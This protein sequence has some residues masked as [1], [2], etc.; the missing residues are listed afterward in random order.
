MARVEIATQGW[1]W[2]A[3]SSGN[4]LGGQTVTIKHTDGSN[5]THWS[6]ITGGSSSTGTITTASNGT[7]GRYIEEGSYDVT[8][9]SD[10][11]R[12]EAVSGSSVWNV[13]AFGAVGDGSTNDTT[14][15]NAAIDAASAAGGGAV[16]MPA[17]TYR[18]NVTL[19]AKVKLIGEG[20]ARTKLT[21][22]TNGDV[23]KG[24]NFATLTG[25]AKATGDYALGAYECEIRDMTID[26]NKASNSGGYGIRIWGRAPLFTGVVRVQNCKTGGIWTE[27]TEVD[28]FTD[29][30]Q[31]LEGHADHLQITACD[32]HGWTHRGPHDF[33]VE[34]AEIWNNTGWA[35]RVEA[36]QFDGTTYNGGVVFNH[37][38]QYLNGNGIYVDGTAFEMHSGQTTADGS[39]TAFECTSRVGGVRIIGSTV[40]GASAATN[41]GLILRGSGHE[42]R[43]YVVRLGTG[44]QLDGCLAS[45]IDVYGAANTNAFD[46]VSEGGPNFISG[47]FDVP[48]SGALLKA[49]SAAFNSGGRYMLRGYGSGGN[50]YTQQFPSQTL[51]AGGWSP[52]LP[53][54]NGT[55][56]ATGS[57][58]LTYGTTVNTDASLNDI[59]VVNAT[60]GT[61]FTIANPTNAADKVITYIIMNS[62]GGAM[63]AITWGG[64]FK[65]AGAFTNPGNGF[66]RTISFARSAGVGYWCEVARTTTDM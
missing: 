35:V 61:A 39:A 12:V 63:G 66:L 26:G 49:G 45:I 40:G 32:G 7:I 10:T 21:A 8:V 59:F 47:L 65:L 62:S 54:S 23:I 30:V 51:N 48:A 36:D 9:G 16:L 24:V 28:D 20:V 18:A 41:K 53:A 42:I 57:T 43:A 25:K 19:K 64:D 11:H 14:A 4:G 55:L 27:F 44:I 6:A 37:L 31:V 5:A 46:V 3:D 15:I 22:A 58:V 13:R 33:V 50:F 52:V 2:V 34:G 56:K 1:G 60:N 38:N 29:P 17:A